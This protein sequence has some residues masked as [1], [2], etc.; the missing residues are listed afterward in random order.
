MIVGAL[1]VAGSSAGLAVAILL[2]G[3]RHG[4]DVD[5]LAAIADITSSVRSRRR[6]VVLAT[7]YALGHALVLTLL[8]VAA[9]LAGATISPGV[10][11]AM[12]R[13]VGATLV[14]MGLYVLYSLARHRGDVRLE[15]RWMLVARGVRR[16]VAWMRRR[17]VEHVE[18]E[19]SHDHSHVG[20]HTHGHTTMAARGGA[21]STTLVSARHDHEHRHVV[22]MPVDPFV[23]YGF[24]VTFGTGM[25]HGVGAE[26]PTQI[27]LLVTAAG[28]G[29]EG[30][31]IGLALIFVA[32]L[33]AANTAVAL[34][35]AM[36]FARNP[37]GRRG[38]V[39][40]TAVAGAASV[41]IG[42]AYLFDA[43]HVLPGLLR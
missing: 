22:T 37:A 13:I 25:I 18:I 10:D 32:G 4:I 31:A 29:G 6:G 14:A 43:V 16:A 36:G 9:V 30:A 12:G 8:A 7:S 1:A 41:G 21:D 19:H 15:S 2:A 42:A 40:L 24:W 35:L 38:Y 28:A 20:D 11:A 3:I 34:A 33:F 17:R 5:H 26:T 27:L 39:V 23:G